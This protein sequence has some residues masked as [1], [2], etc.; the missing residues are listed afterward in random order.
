MVEVVISDLYALSALRL[1]GL[2]PTRTTQEGHRAA[3][4]F[5]DTPEVRELLEAYYGHRLSVDPLEFA[6][7]VRSAKGEAVNLRRPL[8]VLT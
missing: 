3:W 8:S 5:R 1:H 4:V 6:E 2:Q 7:R